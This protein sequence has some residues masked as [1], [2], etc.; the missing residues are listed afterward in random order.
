MKK[1]NI[2]KY[3]VVLVCTL[4]IAGTS[5]AAPKDNVNIVK[6]DPK[7][8]TSFAIFVDNT[9]YTQCKEEIDAY[10]EVLQSEGLGTYIL[11]SDW[12]KPEDVKAQI[13]KLSKI[14]PAL[15]GMVFIGDIPIARIRQAQHMTTAFKM[16]E[17]TF[18]M[19]ESSVTS[20]RFYDDLHLT[21]EFICKDSVNT[22]QFYYNLTEEG[23]QKLNPNFYSARMLVPA[24]F[25]GDKYVVL[26]KYLKKVVTAHKE[27]NPLDQFIFFAGSG[28]NSD[29]MTVW[30]QQPIVFREYFPA[31]F[32]KASGNRFY[33]YRQSNYMKYNLY[34]EIQRP[35]TDVFMFSEHGAPETQYING[36][37]AA[38]T[39]EDNIICLKRG[40]RNY[41][42]RLKGEKAEKFAKE[43]CEYYHLDINM[44]SPEE[45]A[46]ER[47]GDSLAKADVI[48]VLKDI[49]KLKTGSRVTIFNACYN[50]SF[51]QPGYVAGYHIFNDG[52]NVV[53]QGNTVNVLQDKLADQLIG[54]LALG[55]RIGFWQKEVIYLESHLIGDPTFRFT[56]AEGV[57]AQELNLALANVSSIQNAVESS[58]TTG[59]VKG[60]KGSNLI[61]NVDY[62]KEKLSEKESI[63]RAMAIKQL[64]KLDAISSDELYDIF[65]QDKSWIVRLQA[66]TAIA[67]YCD[68][69]VKKVIVKGINDPYEMIR[70]QSCHLAG[71]MGA[72]EF[73]EPLINLEL[74]SNEVI[75]AQYAANSSLNVFNP[76]LFP[77]YYAE[78]QHV[79]RNAKRVSSQMKNIMSKEGKDRESDIRYLRN[80]NL[81]WKVNQL[82]QVACDTTETEDIRVLMTEALGWFKL[83]IEK[84]KIA[85]AMEQCLKDE[86]LSPRLKREM[87][88]TIKRIK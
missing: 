43:N 11:S 21:F 13:I 48:I 14:K 37:Y 55:I 41:Y 44:F 7:A 12:D 16:N 49:E 50:G 62:W 79:Q 30:R 88:K 84:E 18:P 51:H 28:Y 73:I 78:M 58:K 67:P 3:I 2:L 8:A 56:P 70:R 42:K 68:D 34:N 47:F 4:I 80:N 86:Q 39:T 6:C 20:D 69:N 40:L 29:C 76:E 53:A 1:I 61:G 23:A 85:A 24:E 9:T 22:R 31:A 83:S 74:H 32:T 25:P 59:K 38:Q 87:I 35:N 17:D 64:S 26:K 65:C 27:T 71:D 52:R 45:M 5:F 81:H 54:Y 75:R 15:E 10:R 60:S 77:S 46:K 33:N 19:E 36:P 82:I 63:Y 66:L 72:T 57:N